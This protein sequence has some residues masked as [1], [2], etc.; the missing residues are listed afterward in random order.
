[1][2]ELAALDVPKAVYPNS[3]SEDEEYV[4]S[5]AVVVP[6]APKAVVSK[7]AVVSKAST[8]T[9]SSSRRSVSVDELTEGLKS[10]AVTKKS[11]SWPILVKGMSWGDIGITPLHEVRMDSPAGYTTKFLAFNAVIGPYVKYVMAIMGLKYRPGVL[12][13]LYKHWDYA[14]TNRTTDTKTWKMWNIP[15][16]KDDDNFVLAENGWEKLFKQDKAD[17]G[18]IAAYVNALAVGSIDRKASK[19][20]AAKAISDAK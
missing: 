3:D 19:A 16:E 1:M 15:F 8:S 5:T 4:I 14:F 12:S 10:L 18:P 13:F 7:E 2:Q 17:V 11:P 9:T 20:V 6:K